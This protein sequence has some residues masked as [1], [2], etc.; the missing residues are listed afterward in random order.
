MNNPHL[1]LVLLSCATVAVP[2]MAK[3][4]APKPVVPLVLEGVRY[5][6]PHDFL[7][8]VVLATDVK[9]RTVLWHRQIYT[10]RIDPNLETDVQ[11]SYITRLKAE[12]GKLVVA[13]DR[14][15]TYQLD[16]AT[17][18]VEAVTGPLVVQR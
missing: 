11:A 9:T 18:Q 12:P 8:G 15:F 14:G 7:M 10:V 17:L 3:R 5:S 2:V 1:A 6:V 4:R 16:L 13:N